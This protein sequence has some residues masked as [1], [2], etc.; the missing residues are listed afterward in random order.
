MPGEYEIKIDEAVPPVEH[1]PRSTPIKLRD[2]VITTS[3]EL[4]DAGVISRVDEPTEWISL[5]VALR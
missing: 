4:K 3:M 5:Q 1:R 2:D